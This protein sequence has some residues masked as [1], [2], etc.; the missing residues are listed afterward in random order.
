MN[1]TTTDRGADV[2][3]QTP[4]DDMRL[5]RLMRLADRLSES[6]TL[7]AAERLIGRLDAIDAALVKMEK[8]PGLIAMFADIADDWA[9]SFLA[10]GIEP[11]KS[12]KQGLHAALWLGQQVSETELERLGILLRSDVLDPHA[13]AVVG[14]TGR[15]LAKCHEAAAS[16]VGDPERV[17][18]LGLLGALRDPEVQR[19]LAFAIRVARE[20][21]RL[22][23]T[24]S[25]SSSTR[26]LQT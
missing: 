25:S 23:P 5:Q 8:L 20:F 18:M 7:E 21:G 13:L 9:D 22:L 3:G 17:G 1:T 16:G 19:S 11:D 26:S 10:Q 6:G 2:D 14:K 12:L 24:D 4:G 15:A